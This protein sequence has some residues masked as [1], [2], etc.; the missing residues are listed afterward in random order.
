MW[1]EFQEGG[2]DALEIIGRDR[3]GNKKSTLITYPDL[4]EIIR[5]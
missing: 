2:Y 3:D 5:K 1:T 4:L